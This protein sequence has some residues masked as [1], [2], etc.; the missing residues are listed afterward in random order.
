MGVVRCGMG[1]LR[2]SGIGNV[3][4]KLHRKMEGTLKTVGVTCDGDGHWYALVTREVPRKVL[5]GTGHQVGLDVGLRAFVATSD[6]EWVP[7]PRPLESARLEVERAQR[8][9]SRRSR[10]SKRRAKAKRLLARAHARVRN[11]RKDFQHK[12]ARTLVVRNDR[13]AV[14]DLNLKGLARGRLARPIHDA[15]WG[16]FV[17]ILA[18][19]AEEAG[20]EL[21]RVDP[22][23][24]S[25]RC[26]ACD[27]QVP[28]DL[29]VRV[30]Q[31]PH[32]GLVLDRDVNAA[33]NILRAPAVAEPET[34]PG[35]GLRGA[36]PARRRGQ[37]RRTA[38][39]KDPR[40]SL[41]AR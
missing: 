29:S 16:Q 28:K 17:S 18:A 4:V 36:A 11:A 26:S 21:L 40:S 25:Q 12:T 20:R 34:R 38:D 15:A 33:R 1:R 23:G 19:K 31:C 7:N 27:Q 22:R 6:G 2:L 13:L 32:C 9:V 39:S 8:K 14:E 24:T 35:R 30:H 3:K 37:P 5:P 41:L 10:G